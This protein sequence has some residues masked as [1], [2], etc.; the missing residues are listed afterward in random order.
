MPTRVFLLGVPLDPLTEESA[1][2]RIRELL[3]SNA[4]R[5]VMTPNA[6]M[7]VEASR[8]P[9][10]RA[11][12]NRTALNLPDST[13]VVW[14]ARRT[15]QRLPARVTGVD[16][17]TRLCAGLG[18]AHPVFL[19]GAAEGVA[20]KAAA[21]LKK[22]NPML[23]IAGAYAGSPREEDARVIIDRINAAKPHL[24]LVAYGAPGQDLWIDR[25]LYELPS[26]RV[27]IGVG[28]TL[29]FIAG[30]VKR[31]P[32]FVRKLGWEWLWRLVL[33]PRRWRRILRATVVFPWLVVRGQ[34]S[35]AS[36]R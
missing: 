29:D 36:D 19:L 22:R 6:E 33:E 9:A 16:A 12:L 11:L 18:S 35:V 31:A 14:A 21:E 10:F 7:L 26:V 32:V 15:G 34:R 3:D 30:T 5:H 25:H 13:G 4:Q 17:V 23:V 8:N 28:G 2:A 27:A 24:L 1:V 20:E